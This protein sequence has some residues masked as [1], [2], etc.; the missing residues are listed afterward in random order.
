MPR[1]DGTGPWG[2]GSM[3]QMCGNCRGMGIFSGFV[4]GMRGG[5]GRGFGRCFGLAGNT[6]T[7]PEVLKE[8]AAR[9]EEQAANLRNLASKNRKVE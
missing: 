5:F 3:D 9:L 4:R 6:A 7:N 2:T 1:G 8:Q